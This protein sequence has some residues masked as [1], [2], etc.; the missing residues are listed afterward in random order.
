IVDFKTNRPPPEKLEDVPLAYV[1]QLALY[2]ELLKPIYPGRR[3][4]AALLFTESMT[5]MDL[6][7]EALGAALARLTE[8]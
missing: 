6:P 4:E 5:L 1:L 7:E 3:V 2:A 8:A